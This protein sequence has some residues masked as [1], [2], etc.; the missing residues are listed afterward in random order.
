MKRIGLKRR[1]RFGGVVAEACQSSYRIRGPGFESRVV[2][3]QAVP[4]PWENLGNVNC[5]NLLAAT[6]AAL[7]PG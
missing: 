7:C 1:V 3:V 5:D 6:P 4:P 2:S